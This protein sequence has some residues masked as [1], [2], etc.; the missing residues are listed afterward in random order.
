MFYDHG[1]LGWVAMWF[2]RWAPIFQEK[3]SGLIFEVEK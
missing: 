3:N 1:L 2:G